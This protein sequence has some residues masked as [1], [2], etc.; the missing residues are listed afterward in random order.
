MIWG[1]LAGKKIV[2]IMNSMLSELFMMDMGQ[3]VKV[4]ERKK[5]LAEHPELR[6]RIGTQPLKQIIDYQVFK[7]ARNCSI[8]KDMAIK[9]S[10]ID[11]G[12]VI[13]QKQT[14]L[15][16]RLD[17]VAELRRQGF[18]AFDESE[19]ERAF[20]EE[21]DFAAQKKDNYSD[22]KDRETL[23]RLIENKTQALV[24]MVRF[25][26]E[27]QI[28]EFIKTRNFPNRSVWGVYFAGYDIKS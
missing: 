18:S 2:C 6:I 16:V 13:T 11:G 25:Y 23:H 19:Y 26:T 20:K 15:K 1:G 8:P 7:C 4:E 12:L 9:G 14:E 21:E 5:L 10:D 3:R 24:A 28:E 17:F 27:D 22:L